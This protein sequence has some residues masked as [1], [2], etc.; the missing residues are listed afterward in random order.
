[1]K[2][3]TIKIRQSTPYPIFIYLYFKSI[4]DDRNTLSFFICTQVPPPAITVTTEQDWNVTI[5]GKPI[6]PPYTTKVSEG[7]VLVDIINKAANEEPN[8]SY[9]KYTSI[10]YG[11]NGHFITSMNGTKQVSVQHVNSS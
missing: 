3:T 11:G 2:N 7:T 6:P 10:Y 1:M 4:C 5:V 8:A 9:N